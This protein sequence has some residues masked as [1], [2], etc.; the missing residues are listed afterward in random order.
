[1]FPI[2]VFIILLSVQFIFVFGLKYLAA[3]SIFSSVRLCTDR[4]GLGVGRT[5]LWHKGLL[6]GVVGGEWCLNTTTP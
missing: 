3:L 1:M 6:V 4:I 2:N 5:D